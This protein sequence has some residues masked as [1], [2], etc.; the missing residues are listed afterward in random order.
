MGRDMGR[1]L[2]RRIRLPRAGLRTALGL[3]AIIA[4]ASTGS[5]AVT[6]LYTLPRPDRAAPALVRAL[7]ARVP[8]SERGRVT[9]THVLYAECRCSQRILQHLVSRGARHDVSESSLLVS[10][11]PALA[12]Q[13]TAAGF[14]TTALTPAELKSQFAIEAAPLLIVADATRHIRYLGGYTAQKQGLEIRDVAIIDR[15][16]AGERASELP[17]FGCAVSRALQRIAD[18]FG[19]QYSSRDESGRNEE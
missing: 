6:H 19:L 15:V 17:L 10:P 12:Q 8:A 18:P 1:V 3:W 2:A 9:V 4:F 16:L 5:L 7:A 13:L 11:A 14:R